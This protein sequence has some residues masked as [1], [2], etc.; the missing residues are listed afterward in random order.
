ML[1]FYLA[2]NTHRVLGE[3]YWYLS[4]TILAVIFQLSYNND[5]LFTFSYLYLYFLV[6]TLTSADMLN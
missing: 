4:L 3:D 6:G 1:L 2:T 5:R